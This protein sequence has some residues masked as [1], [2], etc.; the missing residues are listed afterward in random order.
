MEINAD[1]GASSLPHLSHLQPSVPKGSTS[2]LIG[3]LHP[4]ESKLSEDPPAWNDPF[5][6]IPH[7]RPLSGPVHIPT[8]FVYVVVQTPVISPF[9]I[10]VFFFSPALKKVWKKGA[11]WKFQTLLLFCMHG[12]NGTLLSSLFSPL[13]T[14]GS[15]QTAW[16]TVVR[17]LFTDSFF[18]L[19]YLWPD[20]H[21][22]SIVALNRGPLYPA[23]FESRC[24][25]PHGSD[26][27][28]E[29]MC[30]WMQALILFMAEIYIIIRLVDQH[31]IHQFINIWKL[32]WRK[33]FR[34]ECLSGTFFLSY[35]SLNVC[36][37]YIYNTFGR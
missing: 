17:I 26:L 31:H 30:T 25:S 18:P 14:D 19:W 13:L 32:V 28:K 33:V 5:R 20:D 24:C 4:L 3:L 35:K 22:D 11:Q 9:H 8:V 6:F 7:I 36:M 16:N 23:L 15:Y 21:H 2:N 29:C 12:S 10:C 34:I 1:K 27:Q 37:Q